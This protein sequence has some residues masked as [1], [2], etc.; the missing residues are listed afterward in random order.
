[1]IS[2]ATKFKEQD[3]KIKSK[4]EAKNQL[5]NYLFSMKNTLI[6]E[7]LKE[8]FTEDDKKVIE[9]S[10]ADNLKWL[11]NNQSAEEDVLKEKL[12]QCEEKFN[13]IMM[14]VY[15]QAGAPPPPG[16]RQEPHAD[17]AAGA[18]G[19]SGVDDLD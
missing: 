16:A 2:D 19:A 4:V 5:E 9:D 17:Q 11:E 1:M 3:D 6:D 12:K 13:P 7:K 14:R 10:V 18:A 8:K 15:Q